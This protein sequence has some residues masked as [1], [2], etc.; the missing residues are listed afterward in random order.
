MNKSPLL[1]CHPR[2]FRWAITWFPPYWGTGIWVADVASDYSSIVI[3][4]R[5]TAFNR[6]DFGTH[7]G[8]SLYSMYDSFYCHMLVAR[9]GPGCVVWDQPAQ[10]DFVKPRSGKVRAVFEWSDPQFEAIRVHAAHGQKVLPERE[11]LVT[12]ES[13]E[14]LARSHKTLYMRRKKA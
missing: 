7:F 13:G 6:N 4:L 12:D 10:I 5:A 14:V 1:Y 2:L 8:R 9:L 3:K 11:V